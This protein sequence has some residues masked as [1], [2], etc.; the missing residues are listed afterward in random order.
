MLFYIHGFAQYFNIINT[1]H[2]RLVFEKENI[3]RKR[4]KF[5]VY[6]NMSSRE[7][8]LFEVTLMPNVLRNP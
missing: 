1:I 4:W 8:L 2:F 7:A 6:L 3:H 5:P